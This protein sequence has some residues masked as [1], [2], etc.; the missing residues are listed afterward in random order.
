MPSDEDD[1]SIEEL[2]AQITVDAY[3]DEAYWSF[4][5][6]FERVA[7]NARVPLIRLHDLRHTHG[8]LLIKDGV[9]V[10]V[11]SE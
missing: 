11:V 6:A 8:S 10:K 4:L 3:D 1:M 9:P 2:I 5:Q 7:H